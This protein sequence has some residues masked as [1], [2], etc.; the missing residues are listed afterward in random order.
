[1]SE[2][3]DALIRQRKRDAL[4]YEAYLSQI[5]ALAKRVDQRENAQ[6]PIAIKSPAQRA[7][8]DNLKVGQLKEGSAETAALAIDQAIR[9]VKKADW[10]NNRFKEREIQNAIESELE[11]DAGLAKAIFEIAKARDDY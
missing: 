6:Y 2:L 8:F 11:G 3:L 1:M 5:V 7:I 9:R 10:R 4:D